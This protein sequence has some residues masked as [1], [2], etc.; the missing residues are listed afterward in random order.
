MPEIPTQMQAV[1]ATPSGPSWTERRQ[2]DVP[3]PGPGEVLLRVRAFSVNRGELALV[4]SRG[5]GWIPGQDLVGEVVALG[6]DV[7]VVAA[8][9]R[10]VAL[11]DWHGWAEYAVVQAHRLAALP[12]AVADERAAALPIAGITAL[13]AVRRGGALLGR[14]V[15]VTGASGGV[16]DLA[17]QLA[18]TAGAEVVAVARAAHAERMTAVGAAAVVSSPEEADGTFALVC[19]GVGGA[20]LDASIGK[21]APD[22]VAVL[23]GASAPEPASLSLESFGSAPDARVEPFFSWRYAE[24]NGA[25]LATLVS[26]VADGRLDVALGFEGTWD[27]LNEAMEA[28]ADRRFGGKAVLHIPA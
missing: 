20:S 4:R 12:D 28:L 7:D 2:S 10:V 14:R 8:G 19:E 18:R 6:P 16:G 11:A 17:V 27:Q 21:L 15:L 22:G 24:H 13:N 3:V 26:F 1:A 5:E 23:Y 25:D 9:T